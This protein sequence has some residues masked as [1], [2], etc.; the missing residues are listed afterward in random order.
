VKVVRFVFLWR[1]HLIFAGQY[2]L[3]DNL[4]FME[5]F[6]LRFEAHDLVTLRPVIEIL[7]SPSQTKYGMIRNKR[8][9]YITSLNL[10]S[11]KYTEMR[12]ILFLSDILGHIRSKQKSWSHNG[13]PLL[14]SGP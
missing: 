14:G 6:E 1:R 3:K 5:K 11:L 9:K 10:Q 2:W 8:C 7:C 4:H 12:D 13:R